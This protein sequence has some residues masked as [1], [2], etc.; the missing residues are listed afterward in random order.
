[1]LVVCNYIPLLTRYT[2]TYS[3]VKCALRKTPLTQASMGASS[4]QGCRWTLW[5]HFCS[6][7]QSLSAR[8]HFLSRIFS[9]SFNSNFLLPRMSVTTGAGI[10]W[11]IHPKEMKLGVPFL[12]LLL[13]DRNSLCL[14]LHVEHRFSFSSLCKKTKPTQQQKV[15]FTRWGKWKIFHV[16][17]QSFKNV[18][19][20]ENNEDSIFPE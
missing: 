15:S 13:Q 8:W 5:S 16:K 20:L 6:A 9:S 3:W 7:M 10:W 18:H 17:T 4:G 1:M 12:Q 2:L 11:I 14:L 19:F